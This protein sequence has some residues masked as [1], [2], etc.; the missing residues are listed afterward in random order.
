LKARLAHHATSNTILS[1][2]EKK[3]PPNPILL[4]TV[5]LLRKLKRENKGQK[6]FKTT[7]K[8]RGQESLK[9]S[10]KLEIA[11]IFFRMYQDI[12]NEAQTPLI[13][14]STLTAQGKLLRIISLSLSRE[15]SL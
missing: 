7:V 8:S 4:L 11:D 2:A 6:N 15:S 9:G 3:S 5:L 13:P 1:Q 12:S 14:C 10:Y